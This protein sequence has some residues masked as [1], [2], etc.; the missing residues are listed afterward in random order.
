MIKL[1]FASR[2]RLLALLAGLLLVAL[3]RRNPPHLTSA[4]EEQPCAS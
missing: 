1:H 3:W 2:R 4:K